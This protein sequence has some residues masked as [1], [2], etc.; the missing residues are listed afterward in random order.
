VRRGW[1]PGKKVIEKSGGSYRAV[2]F[3]ISDAAAVD[4]KTKKKKKKVDED[5][6]FRKGCNSRTTKAAAPAQIDGYR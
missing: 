5:K 1:I 4:V 2:F 6:D 3:D